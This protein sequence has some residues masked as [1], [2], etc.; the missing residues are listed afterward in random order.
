M[1]SLRCGGCGNKTRFDVYETK[2]TRT[3]HHFSLAGE[4]VVEDE[5]VFDTKVEKI[6]CRWCGGSDQI[7]EG[8]LVGQN[9]TAA[10]G[11]TE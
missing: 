4:D 10:E 11:S 8:D 7:I 5:E 3:F 2:R 1:N 6:V 9:E